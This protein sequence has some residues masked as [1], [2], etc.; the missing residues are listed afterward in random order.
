MVDAS[1]EDNSQ[2]TYS[3]WPDEAIRYLI[4][5]KKIYLLKHCFVRVTLLVTQN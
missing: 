2:M 4:F 1:Q 3:A 5:I